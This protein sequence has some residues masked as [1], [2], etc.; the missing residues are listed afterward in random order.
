MISKKIL[1]GVKMCDLKYIKE[2]YKNGKV[3]AEFIIKYIC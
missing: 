3:K 2:K 1:E